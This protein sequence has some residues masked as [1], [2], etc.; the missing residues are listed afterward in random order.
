MQISL[1]TAKKLNWLWKDENRIEWIKTFIKIADKN[2]NVVP[3]DFTNEQ[4]T[5]VNNLGHLNIVSKS[6]QLGCSVAICGLALRE[7]IVHDN[8]CC[9][10]ISHNQKSTNA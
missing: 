8:S 6:R 2:G 1:E 9:V 10:L 4:R 5:L 7:C 3:F